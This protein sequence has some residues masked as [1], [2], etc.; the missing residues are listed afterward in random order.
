LTVESHIH[1]WDRNLSDR[2]R[3]IESKTVKNFIRS[4]T[5]SMSLH[6]RSIFALSATI[7]LCGQPL[8]AQTTLLK[9]VPDPTFSALSRRGTPKDITYGGGKRSVCLT[10]ANPDRG[11]TA[12][13]PPEEAGGLTSSNNPTFWVYIPYATDPS[14]SG[15]LSVRVA[16]SFRSQ[17]FVKVPVTLPA[18][19]GLVGLK[20]PES[21]ALLTGQGGGMLAW[22]LTVVCDEVNL[23]RNPFV[24]GLVMVKPNP[25][26][27]NR[28]AGLAHSERVAEL[29]RSGYWYDAL[30]LVAGTDGEIGVRRL[31]ESA[32]WKAGQ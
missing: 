30:D 22:T 2:A 3:S 11:L 13:V 12:I 10:R 18:S 9:Y 15:V 23:S 5:N 7:L 20:V 31:M 25:E 6:P 21:I 32:G 24:S 29:A 16:D 17:P 27:L 1:A 14:I 4:H 19:P 28:A 8:S 26:L